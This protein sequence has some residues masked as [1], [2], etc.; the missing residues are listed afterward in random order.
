MNTPP[1]LRNSPP[2]TP[3]SPEKEFFN[4]AAADLYTLPRS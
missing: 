4:L 1:P 3:L 2:L